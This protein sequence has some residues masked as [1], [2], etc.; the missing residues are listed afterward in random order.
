MSKNHT[1]TIFDYI[2]QKEKLLANMVVSKQLS[3]NLS[4]ILAVVLAIFCF[5]IN[6]FSQNLPQASI[7][8]NLQ[9]NTGVI[10]T[11]GSSNSV[12]IGS[13]D[14][15]WTVSSVC[16]SCPGVAA[17][18]ITPPTVNTGFCTGLAGNN[19]PSFPNSQWITQDNLNNCG[20]VEG[21]YD[22][23][24][25]GAPTDLWFTRQFYLPPN[26]QFHV[27]WGIIASD[28]VQSI[29]VNGQY[30]YNSNITGGGTLN[31]RFNGVQLDWCNWNMGNNNTV[32][33]H[34]RR[35]QNI[36]N[37]SCKVMGMKV[38][39]WGY[40][41]YFSIS[42]PTLV[43]ASSTNL[44]S[45]PTVASLGLPAGSTY[46]WTRPNTG[47][48]PAIIPTTYTINATA[49]PLSG[50]MTAGVYS[51]TNNYTMCLAGAAYSITVPPPLTITPTSTSVCNGQCTPLSVTG[52]VTYTW[53]GP[54]NVVI[55]NA[56][57]ATA[58]PVANTIYTVRGTT[59]QGC[60]NTRTV[61]IIVLPV[62]NVNISSST[63]TVCRG[64]SVILTASG[65][66][67]YTWRAPVNF[68]TT[69]NPYTFTPTVTTTYSAQSVNTNGCI[70]TRTITIAVIPSPTVV[71]SASP[72][73]ICSGFSS[74]LTAST[75]PTFSWAPVSSSSSTVNVTPGVTTTYS[76]T[77]TGTNGCW[78]TATVQLVVLSNPWVTSSP[79]FLCTGIT[80]TLMASGAINYTWYIGSPATATVVNTPT[81]LATAGITIYSVC[82]SGANGCVS[83]T[84]FTLVPGSPVSMTTTNATLCTNAG[85]CT[86]V[87]VSSPWGAAVNYTWQTIPAQ[88]GST[89]IVCP[90]VNTTYSVAA[91]SSLGCPSSA[92]LAVSIQ[93][94][95]CSQPTTG[96]ALLSSFS[97]SLVNTAYLLSN[98]ISVSGI[99]R[100]QD[101]EIWALPGTQI[102]ILPGAL[103]ELD[104]V[105]IFACG[106][107]MWNGIVVQD[108]G[109]IT[110]LNAQTRLKN[111]MIE[112]ALTAIR[113]EPITSPTFNPA[114][115]PI[116]IQRFI[117][118]RN[119]IGIHVN[120]CIPAFTLGVV[121]CVFSSRIMPYATFPSTIASNSWASA[122]ILPG[123]FWG[124]NPGLKVEGTLTPTTGLVP[125]YDLN[126]YPQANLNLPFNNQPGHI[127][128]KIENLGDPTLP[129]VPPGVYIGP[130]TNAIQWDFN[131]FDGLGNGI[132]ITDGSLSTIANVFQNSQ[133]YPSP[134][135]GP[136]LFGGHG[137]QHR[138]TGLMNTRLVLEPGNSNYFGNRFWNC[139]TGVNLYNVFDFKASD[140]VIRSDHSTTSAL[141]PYIPGDTG[142]VST[143]NRF[144][145]VIKG[146]QFNNLK[147]GLIFN[148]TVD[149]GG[150]GYSMPSG[151][152]GI[153][154]PG[155]WYGVYSD[156]LE[157]SRNF[158]G[159]EVSSTAP[160]SGGYMSEAMQFNTEPVPFG[161]W[162]NITV[163]SFVNSNKIDRAYRGMSFNS[164]ATEPLAVGGNSILI[165]DDYVFGFPAFGYG[166]AVYED[167]RYFTIAS[168]TLEAMSSVNSNN[169]SLM[170]CQ[171]TLGPRIYCN[172]VTRS[173]FGF[174][175]DGNNTGTRW[176]HNTMCENF[177][178]LGL[179]NGGIIGTQGSPSSP[180]GNF[181]DNSCVNWGFGL[182]PNQTFCNFSNPSLSPLHVF[183]GAGYIPLNPNNSSIGGPPYMVGSNV[184]LTSTPNNPNFCPGYTYASPPSWREA[185]PAVAT[186]ID[187]NNIAAQ[188]QVRIYPN[189]SNGILNIDFID[190]RQNAAITI[191]DITGK[192]LITVPDTNYNNNVIDISALSPGAYLIELKFSE[193]QISRFKFVKM[194]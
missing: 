91:T 145:F 20:G 164:M 117:F 178:G 49:G 28:W 149:G 46:S 166:I 181:W 99:C 132:D 175:F 139:I 131:L 135:S 55:S 155:P 157:V 34:V 170:Y 171:N 51:I 60:I 115:P 87:G 190:E 23:Q 129:T 56:S 97:G 82:G 44:Y 152:T 141:T 16:S 79:P 109:R 25:S 118:N 101:C 194:N 150:L 14:N 31:H 110:S 133:I 69:T 41:N 45:G 169:V 114:V 64:R 18:V 112:D 100:I 95:C 42:G 142:I 144:N 88:I 182:A 1:H 103:L 17:K 43:C 136:G 98:T 36:T 85:P 162:G 10:V 161:W 128:I 67:S 111:T 148:T 177:Y 193:H 96:L 57:T 140:V 172:R 130:I 78:T 7:S 126:G 179:T 4:K 159:E 138:T 156:L 65:A 54:G 173:L 174:Q 167:A 13:F 32:V 143:T 116:D 151:W 125:P 71:A 191:L 63:M 22:C 21:N 74:T 106:I 165:E 24:G 188:D 76:A 168:N 183:N 9:G 104:H 107:N 35:N 137:I 180:S 39:A 90:T 62:I 2:N 40:N 146:N 33:V 108:G 147:Y 26:T 3:K 119:Y 50:I 83:C 37:A 153:Q 70:F 192:Q 29:T 61:P 185:N 19:P 158:F 122:E 66:P 113:L 123:S 15:Y 154:G 53:T 163:G 84:S 52:A 30:A 92:S 176:Q 73:V 105:H 27:R 121:G 12:A 6:S 48:T 59:S 187:N 186:A 5:P 81:I 8:L 47:W 38:E 11:G 184:I 86:T 102:N 134:S 160:Y 58:C 189:P 94:I 77:G 124:N 80:N 68:S 72:S 127:G 75:A 93:S 89:I 120:A